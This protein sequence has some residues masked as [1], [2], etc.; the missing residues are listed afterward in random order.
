[1]QNSAQIYS[2]DLNSD[3]LYANVACSLKSSSLSLI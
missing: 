2:M 3:N 1:M